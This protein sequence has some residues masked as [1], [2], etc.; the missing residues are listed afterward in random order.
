MFLVDTE[1][2]NIIQPNVVTLGITDP[3]LL[4]ILSSLCF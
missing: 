2:R 4:K 3:S 1:L